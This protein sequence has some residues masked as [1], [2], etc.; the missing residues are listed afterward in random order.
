MPAP[1]VSDR[2]QDA[3]LWPANGWDN[4]GRPTVGTPCGIKVRW[5]TKRSRVQDAQGN[6]LMLDATAI[7]GQRITVGSRMWLGDLDDW[8]GVG[9]GGTD[10]ELME[11]KA[12]NETPDLKGRFTQKTVGLMRLHSKA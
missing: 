8:L 1:E 6:T 7:V 12:Y 5:L 11:V 2:Y 9:S 10:N 4:H 3:V